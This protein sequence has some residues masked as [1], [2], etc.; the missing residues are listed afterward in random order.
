VLARQAVVLRLLGQPFVAAL[1]DAGQR[2]LH[3]APRTEA[4]I[5]GWRGDA[6]AAG[7]AMRFN[8]ALHALARADGTTRLSA[9]LRHEHEDFDD[10]V[11]A[12]VAAQDAFIANWMRHPPQTNE[13]ARAG[14]IMAAL[15][16]VAAQVDMPFTLLEL[17]SSAGLN[18][19]LGRYRYDLGGRCIGPDRSPVVVAPVWRGPPPPAATVRIDA[20]R[21]VDLRPLDMADAAA[22]ERLSSFTWTD[23]PVRAGLLTQAIALAQAHPPVIDADDLTRWL[24]RQLETPQPVDTCRVIFHSMVLQYLA[25]QQRHAIVGQIGQAGLRADGKRPLAWIG[26]EWTECRSEVRLMLT[27]WPDGISRHLATCHPYGEWI[28][29]HHA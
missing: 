2:Q 11:G 17:G 5:C 22:R 1:L 26:F 27:C 24:P 10:A 29:W 16:V 15:I 25:P 4:L 8:G 7:L 18:L 9:L 6:A 3:R 28:E 20:A 23:D 13:V 12:A 19:N 21:G 14:A